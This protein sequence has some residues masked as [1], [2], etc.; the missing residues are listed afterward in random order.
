MVGSV[1]VFLG[2]SSAAPQ[3]FLA[4]A[5]ECGEAIARAGMTLVYGG[6]ASGLMKELADAALGAGGR[7]VGII[8]RQIADRELAHRGL[9]E[10][11]VVDSM[12]ERKATMATR[13][14]AVAILPGAFGTMDEAFEALT[15]R[16]LGLHDKPI[17]FV[18]PKGVA[19]WEPLFAWA[20]N[21]TKQG[22]LRSEH[23][24]FMERV[25]G[26]AALLERLRAEG[27]HPGAPPKWV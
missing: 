26:A 18:D 15:W 2:S 19:Y 13:S 16:Q 9:T 12:H 27:P 7:V 5:R 8:P 23:L 25:E 17:V 24:A 22:L 6:A 11:V 20:W 4:L 10:L 21:A 1:C 3:S 14:D